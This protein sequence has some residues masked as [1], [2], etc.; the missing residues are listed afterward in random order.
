MMARAVWNHGAAM[1]EKIR[2]V[3]IEWPTFGSREMADLIAYL[4]ANG[5]AKP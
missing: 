1:E 3:G 5:G 4:N 2:D